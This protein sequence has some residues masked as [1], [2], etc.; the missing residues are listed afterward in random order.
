[1]FLFDQLHDDAVGRESAAEKMFSK[2]EVRISD[3]ALQ[4]DPDAQPHPQAFT[5][6]TDGWGAA[7]PDIKSARPSSFMAD[8]VA[9][10]RPA[11]LA[12]PEHYRQGCGSGPGDFGPLL[13][14]GSWPR[15]TTARN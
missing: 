13:R 14:S 1:M 7:G 6:L 4:R 8:I 11:R 12:G 9:D 3:P 5:L 10:T 2:R 15:S